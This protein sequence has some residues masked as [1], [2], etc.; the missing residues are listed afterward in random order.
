MG[1]DIEIVQTGLIKKKLPLDTVLGGKL[2]YGRFDGVRLVENEI[3]D[4]GIIAY[5]PKQIA[6][7]FNVSWTPDETKKLELRMNF[8]TT[9]EELADFMECVSRICNS[10]KCTLT[11][12]GERTDLKDFL[13]RYDSL[14]AFNLDVLKMMTKQI[15]DGESKTLSLFGAMWPIDL[16]M[17]EAEMFV[18]A[19]DT[20]A[21]RDYL[22]SKQCLDVYYAVPHFYSMS[23]GRI[24]GVYVLSAEVR[25]VFPYEPSVPFGFSGADGG[26][27]KVDEWRVM[28]FLSEDMEHLQT[29]YAQMAERLP[30]EKCSRFDG[31]HMLI[32][33]LTIEE[34]KALA[35]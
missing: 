20:I 12:D 14:C 34:V 30:K 8:P 27:L 25:S 16:A 29:D 6:R 7:G 2:S 13:E 24:V 1:L 33:Q 18:D 28:L 10:W 21:F 31:G 19:E 3:A 5:D 17:E 35:E 15:V 9:D 26:S 22:H 32:E 11:V 4:D 23:D